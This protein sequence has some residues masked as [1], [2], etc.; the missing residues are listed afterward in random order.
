MAKHINYSSPL[1]LF[2]ACLLLTSFSFCLGELRK[3]VA[4]CN[5]H[6]LALAVAQTKFGHVSPHN[7]DAL[8]HDLQCVS[9]FARPV[10]SPR[11][12]GKGFLEAWYHWEFANAGVASRQWWL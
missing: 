3:Q 1:Y 5:W 10:Q 7:R 8:P 12:G 4:G 11:L 6:H 2:M 9:P